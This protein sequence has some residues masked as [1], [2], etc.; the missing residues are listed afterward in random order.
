MV[1]LELRLARSSNGRHP[2]VVYPLKTFTH[3]RK[4][5][6]DR[7]VSLTEMRI[8]APSS[9]TIVAWI[10]WG[11]VI[12]APA[13]AYG[14]RPAPEKLPPGSFVRRPVDTMERLLRH[15]ASDDVVMRRYERF[16]RRSRHGVLALFQSLRPSR[17]GR[18]RVARVFFVRPGEIIHSRVRRLPTG[19]LV[20]AHA[21]GE[22]VLIAA[23]GNP[24]MVL[25]HAAQ[26]TGISPRAVV[27]EYSLWEPLPPTPRFVDR[28]AE[29]TRLLAYAAPLSLVPPEEMAPPQVAAPSQTVEPVWTLPSGLPYSVPQYPY[30]PEPVQPSFSLQPPPH[31]AWIVPLLASL[32]YVAWAERPRPGV[33]GSNIPPPGPVPV[34]P[35]PVV[36]ALGLAVWGVMHRRDRRKAQCTQARKC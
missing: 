16:F 2:P 11:C 17:L 21:D 4:P 29:E 19:L 12:A 6:H 18:P 1:P 13:L 15:V 35:A 5:E 9:R 32:F 20:F 8:L 24:V 33:P 3:R 26:S 28:L 34:P 22:P 27:P 25:S 7:D 14:A 31:D 30:D 10:T 36:V 23:C